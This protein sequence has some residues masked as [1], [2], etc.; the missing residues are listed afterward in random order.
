VG[1]VSMKRYKHAF[2][3]TDIKKT[4]ILEKILAL[5]KI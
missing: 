5:T 4:D 2:F 1:P 3:V